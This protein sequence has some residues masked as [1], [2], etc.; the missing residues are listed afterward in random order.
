MNLT[1][2]NLRQSSKQNIFPTSSNENYKKS[3]IKINTKTKINLKKVKVKFRNINDYYNSEDNSISK[4]SNNIIGLK[5][6]KANSLE[7]F[8]SKISLTEVDKRKIK[9]IIKV[10]KNNKVLTERLIKKEKILALNS[11]NNSNY[12]FLLNQTKDKISRN[13]NRKI[14]YRNQYDDCSSF[15]I[16]KFNNK[17]FGILDPPIRDP[18][19]STN[20]NYFRKQLINNFNEYNKSLEYARK[21]YNN[22]MAIGELHEKK[23]IKIAFDLEKKFYQNKYK[24]LK[25][26]NIKDINQELINNIK[27]LHGSS[28]NSY[29]DRNKEIVHKPLKNHKTTIIRVASPKKDKIENQK[30][31]LKHQIVNKNNIDLFNKYIRSIKSRKTEIFNENNTEKS[32]IKVKKAHNIKEQKNIKQR[33]SDFAN[34]IYE[35]NY[36]PY[37]EFDSFLLEN[38]GSVNLHNLLRAI[39]VNSINKYVYNLE[40]DDL[41]VHNP[42]KLK[43]EIKKT[44]IECN[45]NNYK[46]NYNM[47]F[48]RKKLKIETIRRF[49]NIKDSRFGFPV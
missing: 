34:S 9:S 43:E 6:Y 39:K 38:Q 18:M 33:S 26:L 16:N 27:Q 36:Y 12:S 32:L 42:K 45:K 29:I 10:F 3:N 14:L 15:M 40:D 20:L 21:K 31:N 41:L 7:N 44:Q 1:E 47:S 5:K 8:K 4:N 19:Y 46:A 25:D 23:N 13:N 35:I 17:T 2:E 37:E 49:N 11:V 30:F 48:L 22:A 28:R 24:I